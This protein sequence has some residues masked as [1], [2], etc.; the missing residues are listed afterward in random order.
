[1]RLL[2]TNDDG[3]AAPGL[4]A[5]EEAAAS[6]GDLVVVAPCDGQSGCG[7]RVTTHA[8][9]QPV[10]HSATR[11]A[12]NGTP[13][14]CVR[15]ALHGLIDRPQW[16]LSGINAGG[17]LG[18]DVYH[19]GTVAA[20]RE[21]ALHGLPGIAVSHYRRRGADFDWQR[22]A[23]WTRSLLAD[24]LARPHEPG[25]FWNI[26]LPHL[27]ATEADPEVVFCPLEIAPLPLAF[28]R[29][30]DGFLYNGDYHSRQRGSG[31]DV[32]VC[33][34]GRIAVTKLRLGV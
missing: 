15:L 26:N 13:A 33:F 16:V 2:L 8:Y 6:L 22:A 1:M 31:S 3:I 7:H 34:R 32:D 12:L 5:L 19:S 11:F 14:D 30:A 25:T 20:V 18:A 4:E 23:R 27:L 28:S 10:G 21:A 24:L 29:H 9:L 17:N